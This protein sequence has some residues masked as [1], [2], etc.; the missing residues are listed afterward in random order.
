MKV[1]AEL[2]ENRED[3]SVNYHLREAGLLSEKL[4]IGLKENGTQNS[5]ISR[6]KKSNGQS[7]LL[8]RFWRWK[9]DRQMRAGGP[10]DIFKQSPSDIVTFIHEEKIR[11]ENS[12]QNKVQRKYWG[13]SG[14]V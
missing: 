9:L 13:W 4:R 12:I 2:P 3:I 5:K 10:L 6:T 8:I 7:S 14:L 11:K 1:C